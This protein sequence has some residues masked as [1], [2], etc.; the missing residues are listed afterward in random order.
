[1]PVLLFVAFIGL[2]RGLL[3]CCAAD[4][5]LPTQYLSSSSYSEQYRLCSCLVHLA[6]Y[7][8]S[9]Q[10]IYW[11]SCAVIYP[12]AQ[13]FLER[14]QILAFLAMALV[15][16]ALQTGRFVIYTAQRIN[17]SLWTVIQVHN[18]FILIAGYVNGGVVAT[19]YPALVWMRA[20]P[21]T[22]SS[23]PALISFE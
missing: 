21:F 8:C 20:F 7:T 13:R 11:L 19:L 12:L 22:R 5:W 17:P 6:Q 1:M 4:F 2:R 15:A 3:F 10:W 16:L 23:P 18:L 9:P 14:R